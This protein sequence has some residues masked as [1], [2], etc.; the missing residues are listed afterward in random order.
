MR[1]V[2][3]GDGRMGRAVRRLAEERGHTIHALVGAEENRDGRALT[4]ERLAGADVAVHLS[5]RIGLGGLVRFARATVP[6]TLSDGSSTELRA[7]GLQT[8]AGVRV[9]F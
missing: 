3:V 4:A 6:F 2:I 7:G 9:Y 1:I 5:P 8:S